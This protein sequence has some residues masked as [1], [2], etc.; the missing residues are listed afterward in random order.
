MSGYSLNVKAVTP[1]A[2]VTAGFFVWHFLA[3][4]SNEM[5]SSTMQYGTGR[6]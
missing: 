1:K 3:A 2:R 4:V 5:H 6:D